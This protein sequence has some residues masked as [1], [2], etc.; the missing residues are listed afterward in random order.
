[1]NINLKLRTILAA[2]VGSLLFT[3]CATGRKPGFP[4]QSYDEKKTILEMEA[5]FK[6][7]GLIVEFYQ[8]GKSEDQKRA[9]RDK[10]IDG[11]IVL[12]DMHYNQFIASASMNRKSI[13][14]AG[15]AALLGLTFAGTITGGETAKTALAAAAT[16][17]T[18]LKLSI[19]KNFF[20]EKTMPVLVAT[21]TAQRKQV[22]SS[23][24][25]GRIK[26]TSQYSLA[27]A[28][29][30][31]NSYY[32][33]GTFIGALQTIQSEAG[34]SETE[35]NAKI[36]SFKFAEDTSSEALLGYLFPSGADEAPN[37][38]HVK[39][40]RKWLKDDGN[41]ADLSITKFL[42]SPE[43]KA[44]REKATAGLNLK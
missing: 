24:L 11:R 27:N 3:G 14:T 34:K 5:A 42:Y 35:A 36:E 21:M 16:G 2:T 43:Y 38:E 40:L 8:D 6:E 19:D 15:D 31:L 12:M 4:R 18:G 23:I 33:A 9:I 1:M 10:F 25:Q 20:Y 7:D 28:I 39:A 44:L 13:D 29:A 22:L 32:L 17:V 26:P 30:D 41:P 37:D